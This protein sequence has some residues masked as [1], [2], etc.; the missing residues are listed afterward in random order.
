VPGIKVNPYRTWVVGFN[1]IVPLNQ[2]GLRTNFT[3]NA[4]L[5]ISTV[6]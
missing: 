1:A 2:S 3:P 5:E 6:F 4:T